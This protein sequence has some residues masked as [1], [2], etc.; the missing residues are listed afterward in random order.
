MTVRVHGGVP[1]RGTVALPPD[2]TVALRALAVAALCS[3]ATRIDE[4]LAGAD[5]RSLVGVLRALGVPIEHDPQAIRVTGMGLRGLGAPTGALDAG[6]SPVTFAI[7]AGLL[8]AQRFGTRVLLDNYGESPAAMIAAGLRARGAMIA[9]GTQRAPGPDG[10]TRTSLAVAPLVDGE[11]LRAIEHVLELPHEL[12]KT[13]LLLS[14]LYAAGPTSVAEPLLSCDHTERWL[15][16]AG[17]PLRRLG[18]MS[19]F[20]PHEWS[21]EL[22]FA[23]AKTNAAGER[24][25][26]LPGD[27]AMASLIALVASGVA[28]SS[29]TLDNVGWNAT[30]TGVLDALRLHGGRI[31]ATARG[32][33]GGFEPIARAHVESATI[34]GGPIDA[35]LLA[36]AA[37]AAPLLPLL[38][39]ISARG[40]SLHDA[41]F[42]SELAPDPWSSL[43]PI[44]RAFGATGTI[45]AGALRV[46]PL[47]DRV[48]ACIDVRSSPALGL[49]ALGLA[50]ICPGE[51]QLDGMPVLDEHWPGLLGVL[52]KLGARIEEDT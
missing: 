41:A 13:A 24:V 36:R 2:T 45:S 12:A 51:S 38:G 29:V 42:M 46:E 34:R 19:G 7:A 37:H 48:P 5:V 21:G 23:G 6:A 25:L 31:T 27:S 43:A 35:E 39:V 33:G 32:D 10:R 17:V 20:D 3:H 22:S 15:N 18:S 44:V 8:S 26:K 16:A 28:G 30:R 52:T 1:L 50:L 47:R 14:G 9:D 49:L 4:P 11:A 40:A